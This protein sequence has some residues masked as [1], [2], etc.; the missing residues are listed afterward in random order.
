MFQHGSGG[1]VPGKKRKAQFKIPVEKD[2][3]EMLHAPPNRITT[4]MLRQEEL[5]YPVGTARSI[6][7]EAIVQ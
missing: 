3:R 4:A 6:K 7:K 5:V 1:I 2:L